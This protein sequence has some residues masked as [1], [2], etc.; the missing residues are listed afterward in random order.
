[1]AISKIFI[2]YDSKNIGFGD[3]IP[4]DRFIRHSN[5]YN[6]RYIIVLVQSKINTNLIRQIIL[7]EYKP[8]LFKLFLETIM[9]G[10]YRLHQTRE[11]ASKYSNINFVYTKLVCDF[12]IGFSPWI[13]GLKRTNTYNDLYK[14]I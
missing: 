5:K 6:S 14:I 3:V 9:H 10:D 8:E 1:M 7:E 2:V 4:L 13:Q 12:E 11:Y